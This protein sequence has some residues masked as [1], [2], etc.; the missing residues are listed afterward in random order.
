MDELT[1]FDAQ[2][3]PV[4]YV[5][6]DEEMTIYSWDG[7]PLAYLDENGNVY[8]FN[9]KHL[10]WF[11]DDILWDHTGNRCGFTQST[12]PVFTNFE[13]FK[14]FKQFRPFRAFAEFAPFKPFKS[15]GNSNRPL[16]SLLE[17]GMK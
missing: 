13:P 1:L 2:G 5:S 6:P 15:Q 4:V 11:E 14:S 17:A 16:L 3:K 12:C 7:R 10:A 8:G 9:G